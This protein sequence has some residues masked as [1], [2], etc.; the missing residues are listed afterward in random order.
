MSFQAFPFPRQSWPR[1]VVGGIVLLAHVALF[2]AFYVIG[3]LPDQPQ[4]IFF[5]LPIWTPP[6]KS[7]QKIEPKK[8]PQ[9]TRPAPLF[10]FSPLPSNAITLPE[11]DRNALQGLS[12]TLS[13]SNPDL[14]SPEERARCAGKVFKWTPKDDRGM[15]LV[16]KA[17]PPPMTAA[18]RSERIMKTA[19]PCLIFHQSNTHVPECLNKVI[20]GDALP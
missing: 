18:E 16:V 17:Q 3:Y 5:T 6:A 11:Q 8:Q 20:Y 7:P 15:S 13:C 12:Q 19:D 10:Q 14:L 9:A 4:E 1:L 2:E